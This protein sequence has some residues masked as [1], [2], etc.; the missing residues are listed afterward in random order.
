MSRLT[1][2]K[3]YTYKEPSCFNVARAFG[4]GSLLQRLNAWDFYQVTETPEDERMHLVA[5]VKA[6][7]H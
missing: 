4:A 1:K 5:D 3:T 7:A 6:H 2:C